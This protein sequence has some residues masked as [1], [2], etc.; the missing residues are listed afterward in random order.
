MSAEV[1][2]PVCS[3]D[4]EYLYIGPIEANHSYFFKRSL[5]RFWAVPLIERRR[6]RLVFSTTDYEALQRSVYFRGVCDALNLGEE[7]FLRVSAPLR[8]KRILV[9]AP[10]F[11]ELSLIHRVHVD[12][13]Q[14]I[15]RRWMARDNVSQPGRA[16]YLSKEKLPSG[17]VRIGNESEI[18]DILSGKGVGIIYPETLSFRE[19]VE[20]WASNPLVVG[21]NTSFMFYS[22]M[23]PERNILKIS[24]GDD[25]WTN[26]CLIDQANNNVSD[27]LCPEN[28]CEARGAGDGFN[29][30][31][32]VK[33]PRAVA[34]SLLDAIASR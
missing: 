9:P 7:N 17:N 30:N 27:Y 10:S 15:G 31:F 28:G 34:E 18:T 33:D 16:I 2:A 6:L 11:E 19:R 24:Y 12:L 1:E 21:F 22:A 4:F 23:F 26:Q 14:M 29:M 5:A 13:M 20:F 25:M 32:I 8:F 3:A